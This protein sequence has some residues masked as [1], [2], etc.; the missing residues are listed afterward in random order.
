[1]SR[2]F[3]LLSLMVSVLFPAGAAFPLEF[4]V[5]SLNAAEAPATGEVAVGLAAGDAGLRVALPAR[6][7]AAVQVAE[8][9][10]RLVLEDLL[11]SLRSGE[12]D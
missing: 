12:G 1:M 3:G 8:T 2:S 6:V 11:R 7:A 10:R 5:R 4:P 9:P